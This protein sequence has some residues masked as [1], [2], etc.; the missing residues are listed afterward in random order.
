[1]RETLSPE[2]KRRRKNEGRRK[3][4]ARKKAE[5]QSLVGNKCFFCGTE[6]NLVFHEKQGR[7]HSSD[8]G[9][10]AGLVLKNPDAFAVVCKYPCHTGVHFCMEFFGISWEDIVENTADQD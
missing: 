4:R 6:R 7:K 8:S 9:V 3:W 2:E 1:M 5:A 10:T